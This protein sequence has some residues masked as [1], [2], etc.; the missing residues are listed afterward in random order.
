MDLNQDTDADTGI[1][2]TIASA[3][4]IANATEEFTY[5]NSY[6]SKRINKSKGL[7]YLA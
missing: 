3:C 6:N 2:P 1:P 5:V 4:T 7:A